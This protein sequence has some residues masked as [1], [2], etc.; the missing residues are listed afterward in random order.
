MQNKFL[1]EAPPATTSLERA[2]EETQSTEYL[3][4]ILP[5][6]M[7]EVIRIASE[8]LAAEVGGQTNQKQAMLRAAMEVGLT[9]NQLQLAAEQWL[10]L[11]ESRERMAARKRQNKSIALVV[12][13]I[14]LVPFLLF[15]A[16]VIPVV[17]G[18]LASR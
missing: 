1:P 6:E 4:R 11:R 18:N 16:L 13:A 2:T 8:S 10:H 3:E 7:P 12:G 15:L 14:L 17:L 5:D 9:E